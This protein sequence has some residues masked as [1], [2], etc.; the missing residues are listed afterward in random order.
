MILLRHMAGRCTLHLPAPS[1]LRKS[2]L[3]SSDGA[4]KRRLRARSE[5]Y[6][7]GTLLRST[8][9][10]PSFI[11]HFT[12]FKTALMSASGSPSTATRSAR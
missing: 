6:L 9:M 10:A 8:T 1:F 5:A 12:L 3:R 7:G 2:S 11:T 4:E